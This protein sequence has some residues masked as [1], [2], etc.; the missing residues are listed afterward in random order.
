[1]R[2]RPVYTNAAAAD[3]SKDEV[4][5]AMEVLRFLHAQM[6]GNTDDNLVDYYLGIH[7]IHDHDCDTDN[8]DE[9]GQVV[10]ATRDKD[11]T[12]THTADVAGRRHSEGHYTQ[13]IDD[14]PE[15]GEGGG[16]N[17]NNDN[18]TIVDE[19][20]SDNDDN[21][22]DDDDNNEN[23][24]V[25]YDKSVLV[26]LKDLQNAVRIAFRAPLLPME[27][28]TTMQ[29]QSP[30]T[31]IA[32]RHRDAI[33]A[34]SKLSEQ[35][36]LW[37]GKSSIVI[38][39]DRGLRVVVTSRHV[40]RTSLSKGGEG[41]RR[42]G[43]GVL[44]PEKY[45][46][47]YR[48]RVENIVDAVPRG[49]DTQSVV[50]VSRH[51]EQDAASSNTVQHRA[52]QLLG[53]TWVIS[54]REND[55]KSVESTTLSK[56]NRLLE[57][58]VMEG[59]GYT[60]RT[61]PPAMTQVQLHHSLMDIKNRYGKSE[62]DSPEEEGRGNRWRVVQTVNEPRT[63]AVGHF[64]VL[65][66]GEVFEYMSGAD[67]SSPMGGC[68][69]GCFHMAFVDDLSTNSAQVGEHV[70]ALQWKSNDERMFEMPIGRFGLVVDEDVE[71]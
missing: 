13:F 30:T 31:V 21:D 55:S 59:G 40:R 56:L 19:W 68:M 2:E 11:V 37:C 61:T 50:V 5:M 28:T 66:P 25:E 18:K 33:H 17:S 20:N 62:M 7:T 53:R 23:E 27:T 48:V 29:E 26:T 45:G 24:N 14:D 42:M 49:E 10:V 44:P 41:G 34:C 65:R 3:M 36:Q 58:G 6:G 39:R 43:G 71:E 12:T 1:M 67:L 8:D 47:V 57:E 54:E 51:E 35:F 63:G 22:D 15:R 52:V 70:E 64:P 38:D 60:T 32:C 4:G 9:D 69:E 16:K 46:F